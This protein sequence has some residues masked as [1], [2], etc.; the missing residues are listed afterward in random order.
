MEIK[1]TKHPKTMHQVGGL[2]N[3]SYLPLV[4]IGY[5]SCSK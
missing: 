2:P 3:S 4:I 1:S 5:Y